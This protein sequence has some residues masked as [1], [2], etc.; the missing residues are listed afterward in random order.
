MLVMEHEVIESVLGSDRL[1]HMRVASTAERFPMRKRTDTCRGE[2]L[3][4]TLR[5]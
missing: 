4:Y 1:L 2:T 3:L 5:C